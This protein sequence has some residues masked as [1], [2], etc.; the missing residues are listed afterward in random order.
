VQCI[1]KVIK[2][3]AGHETVKLETE[4]VRLYCESTESFVKHC[5][6]SLKIPGHEKEKTCLVTKPEATSFSLKVVCTGFHNNGDFK[7]YT[8]HVEVPAVLKSGEAQ[9]ICSSSFKLI[10]SRD[11]NRRKPK[12]PS[13]SSVCATIGRYEPYPTTP[14]IQLTSVRT[15][16]EIGARCPAPLP[17]VPS[18]TV[19]ERN[20]NPSQQSSTRNSDPTQLTSDL[21][22]LWQDDDFLY[23]TG[24]RFVN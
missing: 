9:T 13:K 21:A 8:Y 19:P 7:Q 16:S 4:N 11:A 20:L 1:N 22:F 24:S 17:V 6:K 18:E 10:G 14:K 12:R 5:G 2:F 23:P 15:Q 3:E